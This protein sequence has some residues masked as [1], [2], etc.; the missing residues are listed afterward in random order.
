MIYKEVLIPSLSYSAP[1]IAASHEIWEGF[2]VLP[3]QTR[4]GIYSYWESEEI[5]KDVDLLFM[6][7]KSYLSIEYH[8]KRTDTQTVGERLRTLGYYIYITPLYFFHNLVFKCQTYENLISLIIPNLTSISKIAVDCGMYCIVEAF[9]SQSNV[10]EVDGISFTQKYTNTLEFL[11]AFV[12][13]FV[14]EVDISFLM[15][16]VNYQIQNN[17]ND[18]VVLISKLIFKLTNVFF[19]F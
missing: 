12:K 4:F 8:L 10:L 14:E 1:N 17:K 16:Y 2:S 13:K 5:I 9:S 7:K 15:K 18:I 11:S 3:Q 19:Y 6:L